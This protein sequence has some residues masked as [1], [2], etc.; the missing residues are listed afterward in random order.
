MQTL[1]I[2]ALINEQKQKINL[3]DFI[4]V[5]L[6]VQHTNTNQSI[7]LQ[8]TWKPEHNE[9]ITWAFQTGTRPTG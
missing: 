8:I 6:S 9:P 3:I 2:F 7:E 5:Y 4:K 1:Q